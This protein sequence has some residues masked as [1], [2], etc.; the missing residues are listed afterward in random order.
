MSQD[1][2][3]VGKVALVTGAAQGIGEAIAR[4]FIAHG[5]AVVISDLDVEA[6]AAQ[7]CRGRQ[8]GQSASNHDHAGL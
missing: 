8:A 6:R 5:A 4:N 7:R 2:R 3:L 1:G